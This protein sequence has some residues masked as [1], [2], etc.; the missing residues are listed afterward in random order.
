M[1]ELLQRKHAWSPQDLERFTSLYRSDHENELLEESAKEA[2]AEAER[3]TEAASAKL[4]ASILARYHEEQIWSDKIRRMSTW[5]TWGLMGLNVLLFIVFQIGVEPWRRKRLVKGFE[6]KVVEALE[7]EGIASNAAIAALQEQAARAGV[8]AGSS[9]LPHIAI[10]GGNSSSVS[11][12]RET[13]TLGEQSAVANDAAMPAAKSAE[14]RQTLKSC[15]AAVQDL[16]SERSVVVRKVDITYAALQ[17]AFTGI[18][19]T[20]TVVTLVGALV[21]H[22]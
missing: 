12:S 9:A 21:G 3:E 20:A 7:K 15:T 11:A 13:I 5:G 2:V 6:E 17:G 1:N 10:E 8:L 16:F 19:F 14:T 4:G 18:V 22:R